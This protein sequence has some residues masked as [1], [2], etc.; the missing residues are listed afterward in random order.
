MIKNYVLNNLALACIDKKVVPFGRK[1]AFTA[2]QA[3]KG[4]IH[5]RPLLEVLASIVLKIDNLFFRMIMYNLQ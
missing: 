4:Q 2:D 5:Q 3:N 1:R